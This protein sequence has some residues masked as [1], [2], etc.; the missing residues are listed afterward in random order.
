M[1]RSRR[2]TSSPTRGWADKLGPAL[3]GRAARPRGVVAQIVPWNFPLMMAAWKLAPAL[4]CGNVA[5]LKP[6]ET[7]PL[8][9]L[10]LAEILEEAEMPPGVVSVL[11]GDG[12]TGAALVRAPGV[13]KVAF[14][15]STSVGKDIQRALAGTGVTT[16][17]ELG[18]KSANI[19]FEDA[20]LEQAV[21]GI[22]NGIFSNQGHVCCAGSR[23]LVQESVADE[24]VHRLWAR[25][26]HLRVG[27]P[28]DKNTDVGAINSPRQLEHIRGLVAA[29]GGRGGRATVGELSAAGAGKLV[30]AD[31]VHRRRARPP[32]RRGGGLRSRRVGDDVPRRGRGG[33]RRPT[34]LPTGSPPACGRTRAH[35]RSR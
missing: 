12:E 23:V 17:M 25:M 26:Q 1:S 7:T 18:G 13:D 9:A 3:H 19:V 31:A 35:V 2:R 20:A 5:I 11:P 15:G 27:D 21:E 24:T 16:T 34:T 28:M 10:L 22:V 6:A 32:D 33:P 14:T 4:A 29:G 30:C 8:T